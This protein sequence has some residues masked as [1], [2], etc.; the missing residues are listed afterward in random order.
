MWYNTDR[1]K[2]NFKIKIKKMFRPYNKI[3]R[4]GKEEVEGILIGTCAI[5]E[6]IDGAN[7][8]I[9]LEDGVV[10]CASRSRVLGDEEFNGFTSYVKNHE[11]IQKLVRDLPNHIFYGE[12]L[13]RHTIH[14]KETAYKQWYMFDIISKEEGPYLLQSVVQEIAEKY[15]INYPQIFGVFKNPTQES[16]IEF[17]GKT[18]IGENGE[19]IVIKNLDFKDKF[20]NCNY[21][22][23][24]TQKFKEDNGIV[25]GGNNKNSDT[26]QEMY[27]VNKYMTLPRV[28]K[29]MNKIQPMVNE[30]LDMKH[31]PRIMGTCY[32]DLITEEAWEIVNKVPHL[33]FRNLQRLCNAKSKQIFVDIISDNVSV[34]DRVN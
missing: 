4:L 28:Q 2:R 22:K 11:G 7:T 27:V 19:G 6:K 5:Q 32:H 23:I 15:N 14:Y 24:V 9:W 34:A 20:G 25:F 8:S 10:K 18:N 1:A 33:D 3:H 26:Y 31:I 29:V 13:V 17:V 21:A 12:W 30:K 16:L